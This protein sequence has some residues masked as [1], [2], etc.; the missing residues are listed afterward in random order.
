MQSII[1]SFI[2]AMA[3]Y[4]KIPMPEVAQNRENT[5]YTLC[6]IPV[7]GLIIGVLLYFWS[8]IC[9]ECGFGQVCFAL[10]G[11]VIPVIVTG[12][13]HIEGF[14]HTVGA[15]Q[16]HDRKDCYAKKERKLE[17]L[18]DAHADAFS[19]IAAICF[20]MLYAAGLTL[21][22][23]EN[24][25]FLL[26]LGFVISRILSG[27]GMV[28]FPA[29]RED[30]V[31]HQFS[32]ERHRRTL[33]AVLVT[34]LALSVVSA[35]FIQPVIGAVMAL[36]ALWVWTYYYYMSKGR[37]GGVTDELTGYFLCLCELSSVLTIG[38]IG[39]VM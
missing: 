35:L 31:S 23:K 18:K 28:W 37:F 24:Q 36:A 33:R 16:P 3:M 8:R 26:G 20:L 25:L 15:L 11:T 9:T 21:I 1:N 17:S 7:P 5:K 19:V 22:W 27:M 4:S 14:L 10:V 2:T 34:L 32:S 12:G 29:A 39:R 30:V 6:F 38:M 13:V